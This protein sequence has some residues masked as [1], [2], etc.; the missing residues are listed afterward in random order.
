[1]LPTPSS[2]YGSQ[3][4]MIISVPLSEDRGK[5]MTI[6]LRLPDGHQP[7]MKKS[8]SNPFLR[9][10]VFLVFQFTISTNWQ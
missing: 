7:S 8:Q 10:F 9:G 5:Y 1:M 3:M 4:R 6:I 2:W